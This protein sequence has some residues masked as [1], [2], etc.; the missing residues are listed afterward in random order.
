MADLIVDSREHW[1]HPDSKDTHISGW[2]ERHC[3]A[4]KVQKLD[5][6]DYMMEGGT[7]SVDRKQNVE[8][9]SGN[10]TNPTDKQRFMREV[11]RSRQL[12]LRLVVLVET[13]K[14][15]AVKDLTSWKSKY[16]PV[17][18]TVLIR[19]ME[20]LRY[21]YGVEFRF[22]PKMSAA[23]KIIEILEGK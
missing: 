22:C 7:V 2:L 11:R 23:R 12:G 18:G 17:R 13:N 4:Y 5:V 6:G 15:K 9:I 20:R 8:E 1:T 10:L 3:I 19:E 21:A 16:T 14:Y